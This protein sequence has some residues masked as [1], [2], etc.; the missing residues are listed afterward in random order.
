MELGT[1]YWFHETTYW[2]DQHW[3]C[4]TSYPRIRLIRYLYIL[5]T[6]HASFFVQIHGVR[7]GQQSWH[8]QLTHQFPFDAVNP[9]ILTR[10]SRRLDPTFDHSLKILLKMKSADVW[11]NDT[12]ANEAVMM[13]GVSAVSALLKSGRKAVA[14][15][16]AFSCKIHYT[17]LTPFTLIT[18]S[19]SE[20]DFFSVEIIPCWKEV[21][22]CIR[23]SSFARAEKVCPA[24]FTQENRCSIGTSI[25]RLPIQNYFCDSIKVH[26]Q[27]IYFTWMQNSD[28]TTKALAL[29]LA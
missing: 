13:I 6:V 23:W 10:L 12:T 1:F 5:S 24:S 21:F 20:N 17:T 8:M 11:Q 26:W 15:T 2:S 9:C 27:D 29:Y 25:T 18:T 14:E 4:W 7:L 19:V 22:S 3:T 16:V 28:G